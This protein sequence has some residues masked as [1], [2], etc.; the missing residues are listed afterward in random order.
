MN[1]QRLRGFRPFRGTRSQSSGRGTGFGG[2]QGDSRLSIDRSRVM[3]LERDKKMSYVFQGLSMLLKN[4]SDICSICER[5]K[6][7]A[8]LSSVI[9]ALWKNDSLMDIA[10]KTILYQSLSELM[11]VMLAEPLLLPYIFEAHPHCSSASIASLIS[12]LN[13][14]VTIFLNFNQQT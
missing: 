2:D 10:S 1:H 4:S 5:I 14:Q 7:C 6:E 12:A 9:C 11:S 13:D 8:E 3:E